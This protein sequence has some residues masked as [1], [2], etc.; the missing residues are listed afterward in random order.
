MPVSQPKVLIVEDEA[1][2]ACDLERRLRKAGYAVSA[3]A[4]SSEQALR[5]IEETSPDLVLMDI[6]LQGPSDGIALASEVRDRFHLPVVFLTAF[7]DKATLE[8]AKATGPYGYLVKPISHVN[9]ASTIDVVLH[10]HRAE[11]ELRKREA[12]LATVLHSLP[13]AMVVTDSSG[14]IQFLNPEGQRL[15]GWAHAAAVGRQLWEVVHVVDFADRDLAQEMTAAT[16]AGVACVLPRDS[17]LIPCEGRAI[18][19]EGQLAISRVDGEPSG[20]VLTFR[21]VTER[22][23]QETQI[24]QE[25]KMLVAG[26]L[27]NGIARDF[28]RLLTVIVR[29]SQ[30]LLE[31]LAEG[32]DTRRRVTAIHRAAH[33]AAALTDQVLGLC[34]KLPAA[35]RVMDLNSLV[36]GFLPHLRRMAGPSITV[37]TR[38]DTELG[39]IRANQDQMEQVLLN[40]VLNARDALPRGGKVSI[41]TGNVELPG[42]HTEPHPFVR[43]AVEDDGTGM[44]SETAE[45]LFEPFF[46]SKRRGAGKG[47]GLAVVHA[48]VSAADGLINVDSNPGAGSLFEVFLPRVTDART[49]PRPP[50]SV[51]KT[52]GRAKAPTPPNR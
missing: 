38:L 7:A 28:N 11:Q 6:H 32:D 18:L 51:E 47:L 30:E 31:E 43:L 25:Q 34:R 5:S 16:A 40:L 39:E 33:S 19:V 1:I 42:L 14:S 15:T 45:H 4:P 26:R 8:R 3:I 29:Y 49:G 41:Q 27:A 24:R 52:A 21:D 37:E 35:A 23:Q 22:N 44:D 17:R 9:L 36:T 2:V 13:D 20:T 12:W 46:T 50:G 48:M 10:K